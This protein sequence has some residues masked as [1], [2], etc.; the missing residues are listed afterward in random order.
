MNKAIK[1]LQPLPTDEWPA[2]L[3][4]IQQRLGTPLNI[5]SVMAH[6]AEL[7]KAW[8]P[9]RYHIVGESSLQPRHR[10][11]LILRTAVNCKAEYE[12]EHHVVRGREAGLSDEEIQRVKDGP[13]AS[14]WEPAEAALLSAADGCQREAK[15]SDDTYSELA[16]H[17]DDRQLLDHIQALPG[18][19]V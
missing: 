4:E 8:M 2:E 6:H 10:E 9:Y 14:G 19:C 18:R 17:F 15:I 3:D 1:R 16:T 7:V 12:W 13:A 5:H 11:L